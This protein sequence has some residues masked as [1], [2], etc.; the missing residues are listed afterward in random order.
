MF[1]VVV[2][3]LAIGAG[4]ALGQDM[5]F[6]SVQATGGTVAIAVTG[7]SGR[8]SLF[9]NSGPVIIRTDS[10]TIAAWADNAVHGPRQSPAPSDD[11]G[12]AIGGFDV[13]LSHHW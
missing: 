2:A 4:T 8:F 6:L 9:T 5:H 7:D 10:L 3:L 1:R 13:G 11:P 12:A